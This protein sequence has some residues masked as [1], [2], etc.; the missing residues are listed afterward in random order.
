[1]PARP[2]DRDTCERVKRYYEQTKKNKR[3][4]SLITLTMEGLH[5]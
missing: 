3:K 5:V 4:V 2:S 1:V